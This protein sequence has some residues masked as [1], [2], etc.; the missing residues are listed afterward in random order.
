MSWVRLDDAMPDH[1]K[2]ND[3]SAEACWLHVCGIA[4]CSRNL[5]DGFVPDGKIAGLL[6]GK[7]TPAT[8][9][10]LLAQLVEPG[11]WE[12]REGGF[13]I[14]DYLKYNP[15]REQVLAKREATRQRVEKARAAKV[16]NAS[17]NALHK[18]IAKP[19]NA[20]GNGATK[21]DVTPLV[22]Q[23][24]TPDVTVAPTPGSESRLGFVRTD[25]DDVTDVGPLGA[26]PEADEETRRAI[27]LLVRDGKTEAG[28]VEMVAVRGAASIIAAVGKP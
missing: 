19:R 18:G 25:L 20:S 1:E 7:K 26:V 24:V 22:T 12:P 13:E 28:A 5:T 27:D 10:K 3:V 14:H 21:G 11:L 15:S 2:L 4:F 16:G 17:G 6:S 23:V 9:R 8:A